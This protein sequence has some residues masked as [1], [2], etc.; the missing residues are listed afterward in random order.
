[1]SELVDE[2]DLGSCA[3]RRPGSSPG[4]PTKAAAWAAGIAACGL[5]VLA[6]YWVVS[7]LALL[8]DDSLPVLFKIAALAFWVVSA[9]FWVVSAPFDDSLPVLFK[10]AALVVLAG[11]AALLAVVVVQR[12]RNRKDENLEEVEY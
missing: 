4:F 1:M 9:P 7:A 11:T 10:I 3:A 6:G 5:A 8:G 12:L 2:H